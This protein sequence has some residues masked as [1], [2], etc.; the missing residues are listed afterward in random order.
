VPA[1]S[2]SP[3]ARARRALAAVAGVVGVGLASM[4]IAPAP[5][6]DAQT[7]APTP[8]PQ[9][10]LNQFGGPGPCTWTAREA[11]NAAYPGRTVWVSEPQGAGVPVPR[12]GGTCGDNRRPVVL[13]AHGHRFCWDAASNPLI[14]EALITN[15]VTNGFV[16]A[17]PNYC[18]AAIGEFF[19]NGTP[20]YDMVDAGFRQAMTMTSR[21]DLANLGIWGHSFGA[22][23][24]PWLAERAWARGEGTRSLWVA[25][26]APYM[27]LRG[28]RPPGAPDDPTFLLP[29]HT[30]SLHVIYQ[31]DS[32]CSLVVIIW[33]GCNVP[34]FSADIYDRMPQPT[35]QRWGVLVRSDCSHPPAGGCNPPTGEANEILLA[36]HFTPNSLDGTGPELRR[37]PS[38]M[39]YFGSY[40]NLHRLYDCARNGGASCSASRTSMGTWS[41][42]VAATPA[43]NCLPPPGTC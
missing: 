11:P 24:S 5:P 3:V 39:Q 33:P 19:G 7:P 32:I 35:S 25:T 22:G 37:A 6:I 38:H 16:V 20:T 9:P 30:R 1:A 40:R 15:L 12:T 13:V 42:G 41:D 26:Y 23:M 29:P 36:D 43:V 27:P 21:E 34:A 14:Y 28:G 4:V 10:A 2:K 31:H 17:F 18:A 8:P